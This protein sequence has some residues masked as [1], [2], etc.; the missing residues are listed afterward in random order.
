VG[1]GSTPMKLSHFSKEPALTPYSQPQSGWRGD[2]PEGLWVSVDGED[3]WPSFCH[4]E[5]LDDWGTATVRHRI[6]LTSDSRVLLLSCVDDVLAFSEQW[7]SATDAFRV[8]WAGVASIYQGVIIA[9]SQWC[10]RFSARVR[11][12]YGWD[13]ASGCIW[14]ADAIGRVSP[15]DAP[16]RDLVPAEDRR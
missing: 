1:D 10:L 7:S 12:Y 8:N 2:K 9:P 13:C 16:W 11:W 6:E 3:D 15:I 14:D 5:G 4:K